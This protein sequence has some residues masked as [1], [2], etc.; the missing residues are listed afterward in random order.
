MEKPVVLV[1]GMPRSGTTPIGER[2]CSMKGAVELYEPMNRVVGDNLIT[3]QF[4]IPGS[5]SFSL[6]T[7]DFTLSRISNGK[8]FS[9]K[10]RPSANGRSRFFNRT[11][12]T[13]LRNRYYPFIRTRIWKDPFAYFFVPYINKNTSIPIVIT[14]RSPLSLVASFKRMGWHFNITDLTVRLLEA[15]LWD[16]SFDIPTSKPLEPVKSAIYAW[17]IFNSYLLGWIK[18]GLDVPIINISSH[19]SLSTTVTN[20]LNAGLSLNLKD[21]VINEGDSIETPNLPR[22]A[23]IKNR[24]LASMNNYWEKVLTEEEV[25]LCRL[26]N[27]DLWEEINNV[28]T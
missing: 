11:K 18:N 8:L 4:E 27:D 3:N 21:V 5:N 22:K 1:T 25:H 7:L 24:S 2:L 16:D 26:V 20:K 10:P 17:K 23:H 9:K 6:E 19:N 28:T 14:V 15:D 13:I 12:R